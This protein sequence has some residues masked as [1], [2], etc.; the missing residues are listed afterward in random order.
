MR[1]FCCA[2]LALRLSPATRLCS[3]FMEIHLRDLA[4]SASACRT[5]ARNRCLTLLCPR[6]DWAQVV[7]VQRV[8]V[9]KATRPPRRGTAAPRSRGGTQAG[10]ERTSRTA[11]DMLE[12]QEPNRTNASDTRAGV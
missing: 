5:G 6:P 8:S 4:E 10:G 12:S 3:L 11:V 9:G 1:S 2:K 7:G